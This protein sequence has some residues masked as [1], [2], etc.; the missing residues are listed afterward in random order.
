M[1]GTLLVVLNS[2]G[3]NIAF[4]QMMRDFNVS[5]DQIQWA[6]TSYMLAMAVAMPTLGRLTDLLGYRKLF[7]ICLFLFIISSLLCAIAWNLASLVFFRVF[8]GIGAGLIMSLSMAFLFYIYPDDQRGAAMGAFGIGVS[9]GPVVGPVMAGYLTDYFSWRAV[10]YINFPLGLISLASAI[11]LIPEIGE[12]RP[13]PMDYKGLITLSVFLTAFLLALSH[14][15]Q[16][17]WDSG[18]ILLLFTVAL[19]SL[20]FFLWAEFSMKEPLIDLN[21]YRNLNFSIGSLIGGFFGLSLMSSIFLVSLFVQ[22][23]LGYTPREAGLMM[24]PGAIVMGVGMLFSGKLSDR[25]NPRI[26]LVTGLILL[27]VSSYWLT[28]LN[29]Q[30]SAELVVAMMV[31]RNLGLSIAWSPLMAISVNT[32]SKEQ[33]GMGTGLL[34]IVRQGI[35][36]SLGVALGASIL[37]SRH[38]FHTLERVKE[39]KDLSWNEE[40]SDILRFLTNG[41][42]GEKS[43]D[44]SSLVVAQGETI[45][46]QTE[47]VAYY[48]CFMVITFISLLAIVPAFFLRRG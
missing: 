39:L 2:T 19:L 5:A 42:T 20:F 6:M 13:S 18:Y 23:L 37:V 24:A 33:V 25:W 29:L 14:G 9:F 15:P 36:G 22:D 7:L 28:Y 17:G 30:A 38:R 46:K 10:F 11:R 45:F 47:A 12:R 32:L 35:G 34:N 48:D 31:F 3:I 44:F 8:Q 43:S 41:A 27:M 4:P 16:K 40:A 1:F 21:L 26:V